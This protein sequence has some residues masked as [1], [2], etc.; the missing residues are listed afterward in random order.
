MTTSTATA[1][2]HYVRRTND[3][4]RTSWTGPLRSAR[5]AD[6]EA[7]AWNAEGWTAEVVPSTPETRTAV[8][9]WERAKRGR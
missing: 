2:S 5:Q 3:A 1:T 6:R 7:T 4:G 9:D 8:R